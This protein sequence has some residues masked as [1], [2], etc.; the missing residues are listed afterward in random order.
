MECGLVLENGSDGKEAEVGIVKCE[1]IDRFQQYNG[2]WDRLTK[3]KQTGSRRGHRVWYEA[4][5]I[6]AESDLSNRKSEKIKTVEK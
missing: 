4:N 1:N 6:E 5:W 3:L 2:E